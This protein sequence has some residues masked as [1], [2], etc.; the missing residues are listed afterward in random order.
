MPKLLGFDKNAKT[1]KGQ[2]LGYLTGILY[3]APA[4]L[5]GKNVCPFASLGCIASCLNT[6]G[7]GIYTNVQSARVRKTQLF[8]ADKVAFID[9]LAKDIEEGIKKAATLGLEFV[10]RL[11]G[12]SDIAWELFKGSNG[13]TLFEMFPNTQFY[14]YTKIPKRAVDFALGKMPAN[15]HITFSRNEETRNHISLT[16]VAKAGGTVA[17][18]FQDD[19]FPETYLGLPVVNGDKTDL[20][21]LDGKGVVVGLKAKGKAKGDKTGFVVRTKNMIFKKELFLANV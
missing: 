4:S 11:N 5:S 21:F 17:V 6:A 15:Y 14:D 16:K 18:V 10:V 12:T 20:R 3:L 9:T 8:H 19:E 2:S 13:K 7:M 1:I